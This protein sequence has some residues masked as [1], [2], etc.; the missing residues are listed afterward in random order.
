MNV[1]EALRIVDTLLEPAGLSDAQ[2]RVFREVWEGR[3]YAEI[4]A[5]SR[6]DTDYLKHIGAQLWRLLSIICG[7]KVSK[8][9]FKSVLRRLPQVHGLTTPL[10]TPG[11]NV[12]GQQSVN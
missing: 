10:G 9:N 6:Y 12:R 4:A 5:T 3:T 1:E 11:I 2:E 8:S 7:E